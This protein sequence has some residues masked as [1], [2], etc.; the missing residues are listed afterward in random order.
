M[1]EI[2]DY[3]NYGRRGKREAIDTTLPRP[4]KTVIDFPETGRHNPSQPL[5]VS[6]RSSAFLCF[7]RV[8]ATS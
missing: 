3:N 4:A 7:R 2:T 1:T 6:S 5:E 8:G